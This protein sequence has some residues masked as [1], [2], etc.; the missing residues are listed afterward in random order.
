M[1]REE[2]LGGMTEEEGMR[3]ESYLGEFSKGVLEEMDRMRRGERHRR[4]ESLLERSVSLTSLTSLTILE[5]VSF[6]R[7]SQ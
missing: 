6:P 3:R 7:E 4:V 2:R 1:E 5:S